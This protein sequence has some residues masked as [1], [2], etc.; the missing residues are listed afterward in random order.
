MDMEGGVIASSWADRALVYA[1]RTLDPVLIHGAL[2]ISAIGASAKSL[3]RIATALHVEG[4]RYARANG[5][6]F[7]LI[8][9]LNNVALQNA[10]SGDLANAATMLAEAIELGVQTGGLSAVIYPLAA[11]IEYLCMLG[12]IDE[13]V[14]QIALGN[15][16]FGDLQ[17]ESL[18][19]H[20]EYLQVAAWVNAIAGLPNDASLF[21][22][23]RDLTEDDIESL[24][25]GSTLLAQYAVV[26]KSADRAALARQSVDIEFEV[27]GIGDGL[28]SMWPRAAD[29]N[30][31]VADYDGLRSMFEY[32]PE[33][34]DNPDD[35]YLAIQVRRMRASLEAVDPASIV[36]RIEVEVALRTSLEELE[37][38]SFVID[39]ARTLVVLGRFLDSI[40]RTS[41]ASAARDDAAA[42]LRASGALG[43]MKDLGLE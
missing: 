16:V 19:E 5:L 24:R 15:D 12:R 6:S 43:L 14:E 18:L 22:I 26:A 30:F 27:A 29:I 21:P 32:L 13:A 8:Q 3:G 39:R 38:L 23:I 34:G 41:G 36:P 42:L 4:V 20:G 17:R 9:S 2:N 37:S 1:E 35:R 33:I 10:K 31:D 11:R 25:T 28:P 40:G 7:E